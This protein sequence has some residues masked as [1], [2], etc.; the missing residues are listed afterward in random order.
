MR[1]MLVPESRFAGFDRDERA[2]ACVRRAQRR[3]SD[4]LLAATALAGLFIAVP[5]ARAQNTD[6]RMRAWRGGVGAWAGQ[7][8]ECC[9]TFLA[10]RRCGVFPKAAMP[11]LI[12]PKLRDELSV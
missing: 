11:C 5:D 1:K 9:C 2:G 8:L 3:L 12:L 10:Q 7:D 6:T 4:L